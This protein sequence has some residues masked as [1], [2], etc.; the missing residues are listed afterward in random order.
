MS[1]EMNSISPLLPLLHT[2]EQRVTENDH[3]RK[4]TC[5]NK[6]H[7]KVSFTYLSQNQLI[8]FRTVMCFVIFEF[9]PDDGHTNIFHYSFH[10]VLLGCSVGLN[11]LQYNR[12]RKEVR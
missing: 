7:R 9:E 8:A 11:H 6:T 5:P 4:I 1:C 10:T 3:K 12:N 2:K